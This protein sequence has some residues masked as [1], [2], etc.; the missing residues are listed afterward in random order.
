M[1][2]ASRGALLCRLLLSSPPRPHTLSSHYIPLTRRYASPASSR[3]P[4]KLRKRKLTFPKQRDTK[5]ESWDTLFSEQ[6]AGNESLARSR[7]S[8]Y[9]HEYPEIPKERFLDAYLSPTARRWLYRLLVYVPPLLLLYTEF[10]VSVEYVQGGSM[11]PTLNPEY[12]TNTPHGNMDTDTVIVQRLMFGNYLLRPKLSR[13]EIK[14]GDIVVY[15]QPVTGTRA[16]KRVVGVPGDVVIPLKGYTAIDGEDGDDDTGNATDDKDSRKKTGIVVPYNHIWVEG[17]VGVR[18]KSFDSNWYGPISQNLVDGFV[19][20]VKSKDGW[21]VL[22]PDSE[23]NEIYPAKRD[24]RVY[25]NAV[26]DAQI[27]PD[28]QALNQGWVDGTAERELNTLRMKRDVLPTSM[29]D[30]GMLAKLRS[31]YQEAATNMDI[32]DDKVRQIAAGIEEELG[33][34]FEKAGLNRNGSRSL[35]PRQGPVAVEEEVAQQ[36]LRAYLEKVEKSK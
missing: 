3:P 21:R 15:T 4:V 1:P 14:R 8:E 13:W 19:K 10:P 9:T 2:P 25:E 7:L 16:I 11:T 30:P 22:Q 33:S 18:K 17:D 29:R 27:N 24:G 35:L 34:A 5:P 36:R 32:E 6:N 12:D 28:Q 20:I 31:L 23:T 26:R